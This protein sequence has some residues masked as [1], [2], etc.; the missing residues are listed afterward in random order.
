MGFR[1]SQSNHR[2]F[3]GVTDKDWFDYLRGIQPEEVNFWKPSGGNFRA[4]SPGDM[5]L[6]KLHS[7]N[8]FI[9]GGGFFVRSQILRSSMAWDVFQQSNGCRS[10]GEL[11]TRIQRYRSTTEIDPE[12]GCIVLTAPFFFPEENWISVSSHWK[13]NIVQGKG[14]STS[15]E[16]GASIW[17]QVLERLQVMGQVAEQVNEDDLSWLPDD[18]AGRFGNEI[19]YRPRLGQGGFRLLVTE[20]YNRKCSICGEKTLPVLE[21]AHVMPYSEK[22]PHS[23]KNGLLLR[24]DLHIL[25]DRGYLT[26]TPDYHI[27]VSSKIREEFQNGRDYYKYHGSQL[28]H[29][30]KSQRAM[31]S[32]RYLEWHNE[33]RFLA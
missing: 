25:F 29:L 24:S 23:P 21:A 33:N 17:R 8:D 7:P 9:V 16:V 10:L 12:I 32:A 1:Y 14:Y 30:P 15:G 28:H 13:K 31:P 11:R 19:L 6:F 26:V 2:F 22:G 18:G 20:A 4:L 5:F 3:V 27:E